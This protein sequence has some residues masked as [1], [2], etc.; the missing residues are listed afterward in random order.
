MVELLIVTSII[1][2]VGA[3]LMNIMLF[4]N[5]IFVNQTIKVT[6]GLSLNQASLEIT[7]SIKASAGIPNQYPPTGTAQYT[8]DANTL[9]IKIPAFN[10]SGVVIDSVFDY[11]VIQADQ[12]NPAILRK[13]IFPDNLS[14][15]KSADKVLSTSLSDFVVN[16]LDSNDNP[17][18]PVQAARVKFAITLYESHGNQDNSSTVEG[19][20]NLKY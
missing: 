2:V 11:I 6:Q 10:A 15:R 8:T 20:V 19:T 16:Y 17:I 14:H 3:I 12:D 4:S 7:D 5:D 1:G 9:I 18:T 13:R